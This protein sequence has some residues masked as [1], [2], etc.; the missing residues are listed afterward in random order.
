MILLPVPTDD[1][2]VRRLE[3]M[4]LEAIHFDPMGGWPSV[5]D[6]VSGMNANIDR[7]EQGLSD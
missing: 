3:A 6:F 1:A 7:L 2:I 5:G 4:D